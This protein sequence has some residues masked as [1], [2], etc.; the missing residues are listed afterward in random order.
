M[1]KTTNFI[2]FH[3]LSLLF[4]LFS[5][6]CI[7]GQ[8]ATSFGLVEGANFKKNV[9][10]KTVDGTR[11]VMDIFYPNADKVKANNP[12]VLFIHGGGW[13]GGSKE[14]IYKIAFSGTLKKMLENGVVCASVAY[15]LAK[16]PITANESVSDC[17]DA[18][19]FLLKNAKQFLLD[20]EYYGVWGG[21]AGGHLSLVT[22]L[23]PDSN[24][25]SDKA[26]SSIQP[27]FK[28][29]A[30]FYP[31]TSCLNPELRP[32]SIFADST[33]FNRLLG[34]TLEEKPALAR[35]LSPTEFLEKNSPPILLVHG[36]KDKTLPIINSQYMI[37]VAKEKNAKATLLTVTNGG[38]SFSGNITPSHDEIANQTA[39]FMLLYLKK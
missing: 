21:S 36:D 26:L 12:W 14:D 27:K 25:A 33:L 24:F 13:A 28:C 11:L 31:F 5:Q 23:V 4:F 3:F 32:N 35:L 18:A 30:S 16:A 10:Y 1:K 7:Y 34:G 20:K 15:R 22:A 19:K 9:V 37:A 38:H 17:K 29:V 2:Q 8:D 6:S 39:N